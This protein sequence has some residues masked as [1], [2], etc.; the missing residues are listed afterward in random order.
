MGLAREE[1]RRVGEFDYVVINH[2]SELD[3]TVDQVLHII[4]AE[5]CRVQQRHV[6]L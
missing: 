3:E 2:E 1:M 4:S 5:H 6:T